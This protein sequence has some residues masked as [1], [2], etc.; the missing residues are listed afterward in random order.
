ME[1]FCGGHKT[2]E[3]VQAKDDAW[4]FRHFKAGERVVV[5]WDNGCFT[6]VPISALPEQYRDVADNVVTP[7]RLVDNKN[8]LHY[9]AF[10]IVTKE[11]TP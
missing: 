11:K 7:V 8:M 3:T 2:I 4:A 6:T 1:M 5:L 9:N 10:K